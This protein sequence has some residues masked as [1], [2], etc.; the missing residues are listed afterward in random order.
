MKLSWTRGQIS[1][2]LILNAMIHHINGLS[3]LD[4]SRRG[5]WVGGHGG[6]WGLAGPTW[7]NRRYQFNIQFNN[8][9]DTQKHVSEIV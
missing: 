6:A 2:Q 3:W 1:H 5:G 7:N 4:V 8:K 9:F